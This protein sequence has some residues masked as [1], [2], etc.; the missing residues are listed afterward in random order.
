MELYNFK[1]NFG[2]TKYKGSVEF[3]L[4]QIMKGENVLRL[5]DLKKNR[6]AGHL[7]FREYKITYDY[8]LTDYLKG[9]MEITS[10]F[11]INFSEKNIDEN[12]Q[13]L[14]E[15]GKGENPYLNTIEHTYKVLEQFTSHKKVKK[16]IKIFQV[17]L[18][19][20][21]GIPK[22]PDQDFAEDSPFYPCN[23]NMEEPEVEGLEAIQAVYETCKKNSDLGKNF[24]ICESIDKFAEK[25]KED[26]QKNNDYYKILFV[27]TPMDVGD[28]EDLKRKCIQYSQL[29][30]SIIFVE[31][32]ETPLEN[33]RSLKPGTPV[34]I[35]KNNLRLRMGI[36][37]N[38]LEGC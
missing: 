27:L 25:V 17:G 34:K 37:V 28:I 1:G 36:W 10:D 26:S 32:T 5:F 16:N 11:L 22:F 31:M 14:H 3:K 13:N 33:L 9:G 12:K 15:L 21:S 6:S 24:Q 19:A 30:M 4:P 29:P 8:N 7:K 2:G 23:G 18:Y 35:Q 38:S 20:Y